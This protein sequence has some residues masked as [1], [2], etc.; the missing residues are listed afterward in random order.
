M[1]PV[2]TTQFSDVI[3]ADNQYQLLDGS[4]QFDA[5]PDVVIDV[6]NAIL[7]PPPFPSLVSFPG[8]RQIGNHSIYEYVHTYDYY[9]HPGTVDDTY[10]YS[11]ADG[12]NLN[13]ID[14]HTNPYSNFTLDSIV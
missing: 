12:Y 7:D 5:I 13:L 2:I 10:L 6:V 9:D 3:I 8:Y 1:S 11:G 4:G 14:D